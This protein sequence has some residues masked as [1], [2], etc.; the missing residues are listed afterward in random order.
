MFASIGFESFCDRLLQ[1]FCKGIT[2]A[3]IVK[4]VETLRRLKDRFGTPSSTDERDEGANHGF[5]RPTPWD[6]SETLQEMD[7]NIFLYRFFEDILPEHS[8]PLIIHHASYL[9]DWIRQI[10][11][12]RVSRSAGMEPGSNG[13]IRPPDRKGTTHRRMIP[14]MLSEFTMVNIPPKVNKF[15]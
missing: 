3:D 6:D 8:T 1:Y 15:L 9:G 7:R 12:G 5:I 10:E 14:A 13:G 11:S 2:V 4:C